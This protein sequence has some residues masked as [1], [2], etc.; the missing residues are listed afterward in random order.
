LIQKPYQEE[1]KERISKKDEGE[2]YSLG[3]PTFGRKRNAREGQGKVSRALTKKKD[4]YSCFDVRRGL[5]KKG[6]MRR[7]TRRPNGGGGGK[8]AARASVF[9]MKYDIMKKKWEDSNNGL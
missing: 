6:S 5:K 2:T 4:P 3:C 7:G 9:F 1:E 8:T